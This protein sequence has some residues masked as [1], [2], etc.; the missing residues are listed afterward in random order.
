ME[1]TTQTKTLPLLDQHPETDSFREAVHAGLQREQKEIPSK[2][3]YDARG[4]A[5]F[6]AI[7]ELDE[8][9]P[10]RTEMRIM[11]AH[12]AA[13][14]EAV[15]PRARLLEYG[16]GSSLKTR[17]L[18][19]HLDDPALYVPIDISREHLAEAAQDL[20]EAY[21][22]VPVQPVCADYTQDMDLPEPP[23]PA[24]RT[25][26]YYPG[27]TIGN[28]QPE[29]AVDFLSGVADV[30][31]P[32]GGLLIGVDLQKDLDVLRAAYN[33]AEGVTAA[34]NKNLLRRI[35]RELEA[36]FDLDAF[37]H[38]AIWNADEGCIEMHLVSREAQAVSV[39]GTTVA[40]DAGESIR[41]EYS[42]KFT[43]E[44]F[45]TM[46]ADAG[47][48]VERVWTDK[49]EYFSIQYATTA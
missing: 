9:Y 30:V 14:A 5:L 42:Y 15:G 18:L 28:F 8:Y 43:R 19:D 29:A 11:R 32:G 31:G 41:T 37:E 3:L 34:F 40:F 13:M 38:R 22:D 27:S 4:S 21:P 26:V 10:T 2:F 45:A 17:I 35:N 49:D 25:V 6:D 39:G 12:G 33:D 47:F 23:M 16:S 36:N 24:Q 48:T 20:A 46:A 44:G 1:P 7:C